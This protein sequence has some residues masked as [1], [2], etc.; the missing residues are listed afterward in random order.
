LS[1][2]RPEIAHWLTATVI[3]FLGLLLL[4]EVI[5]GSEVFRRR[6]WRAYLW[7]LLAIVGGVFLWV[8]AAFST[9]STMHLLAHSSWAQAAM[10]A[11]GVQLAVARGKLS[12]P[13][14]SLVTAAALLLSGASFLIHEQNGWLFS[15]S[16]FLHHLIGWVLVVAAL[17]PIG[18]A[19]RPRRAVWS[20]GFAL[21]FVV[22]AVLLFS[23]RDIAPIFGHLSDLASRPAP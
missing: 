18:E 23:D 1:I 22:L 10:I 21:T 12:H 20:A 11:G 2:P 6:P 5:V 3:L 19:L 7:P 9:F 15:R 13:A 17:F 14:W 16:A 8:I 4:A